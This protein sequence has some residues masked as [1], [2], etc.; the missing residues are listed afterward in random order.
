ML[1]LEK[2]EQLTRRYA[3]LD[4]LM[5][6]P[7]VLGD[8]NQLSKLKM[9]ILGFFGSD[10]KSIPVRDVQNFRSTLNDLGKNA[11]VLIMIGADHGFANPSGSNYDERSATEAWTKTLEFLKHNL[12]IGAEPAK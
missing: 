9:P 4:E 1:P 10:D 11:E 3:E 8:R 5:C 7:D 2:L 12:K 6:R